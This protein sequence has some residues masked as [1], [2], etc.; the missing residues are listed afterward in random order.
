MTA[1]QVEVDCGFCGTQWKSV[2]ACI[3]WCTANLDEAAAFTDA[4][5]DAWAGMHACVGQLSCED[6]SAWCMKMPLRDYP[7]LGADENLSF[8]CEGQ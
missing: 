2:E 5:R 1:C 6:F 8:E 4:C 7:C 3:E